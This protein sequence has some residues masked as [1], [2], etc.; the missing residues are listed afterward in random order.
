[1][2]AFEA[3]LR[4]QRQSG[5][6]IILFLNE[7]LF[8]ASS[9]PQSEAYI[10][11]TYNNVSYKPPVQ[12]RS[13]NERTWSNRICCQSLRLTRCSCIG[14]CIVDSMQKINP[15]VQAQSMQS[16]SKCVSGIMQSYN[17]QPPHWLSE[18]L[19]AHRVL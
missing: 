12:G 8:Y 14:Y 18:V 1:M 9:Q 5:P 16:L 2:A 10:N 15:Y 7:D 6:D 13:G 17:G 3:D 4:A 11:A 19:Q